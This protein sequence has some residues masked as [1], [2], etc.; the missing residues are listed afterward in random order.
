LLDLEENELTFCGE[1]GP[2]LQQNNKIRTLQ[3]SEN[4]IQGKN[5]ENSLC[6]IGEAL[7]RNLSIQKI[8]LP[9]ITGAD[10]SLNYWFGIIDQQIKRNTLLRMRGKMKQTLLEAENDSKFEPG[11]N[12]SNDMDTI[13]ANLQNIAISLQSQL[14]QLS[15]QLQTDM[16]EVH[17]K[18]NTAQLKNRDREK[19]KMTNEKNKLTAELNKSHST[20]NELQKSLQTSKSEIESLLAV[21]KHIEVENQESKDKVKQLEKEIRKA[22]RIITKLHQSL[23][24]TINNVPKSE[25][26]RFQKEIN[27]LNSS[28]TKLL[29]DKGL[30]E[31]YLIIEREKT[32]ALES[33]L[34]QTLQIRQDPAIRYDK[35]KLLHNECVICQDREKVIAFVPCGH[36]CVCEKCS[37]GISICPICRTPSIA[38]YRIFQ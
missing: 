5:L 10:A 23:T 16:V 15:L 3:L 34:E 36:K 35:E 7:S 6:I 21:I 9:K 8:T 20:V 27:T 12:L 32:K 18:C 2:L 38:K 4:P 25:I 19:R 13:K 14:S 17:K 26:V 28:I 29:K 22:D 30:S 37:I 33:L 11:P 24:E 31:R 1:F